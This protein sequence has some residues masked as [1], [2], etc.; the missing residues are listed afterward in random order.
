V[1]RGNSRRDVGLVAYISVEM[2]LGLVSMLYFMEKNMVWSFDMTL[3]QQA[4][5]SSV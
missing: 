1:E 5:F 3:T 2:L 4:M